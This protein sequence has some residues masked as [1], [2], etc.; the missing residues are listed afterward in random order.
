[1]QIDANLVREDRPLEYVDDDQNK[2]GT[3]DTRIGRIMGVFWMSST[4]EHGGADPRKFRVFVIAARQAVIGSRFSSVTCAPVYSAY[5]GLLSRV[6][7]GLDE[8]LQPE[9][10]IHCDELVSI[11]KN[12]L[13]DQV[14]SPLPGEFKLVG[15]S[16]FSHHN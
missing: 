6:S 11:P 4:D 15:Y 3:V 12:V 7:V 8:G 16:L 5:H 13:A 1:M 2:L 9:S 14:G 10:A